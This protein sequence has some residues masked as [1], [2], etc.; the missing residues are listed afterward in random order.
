MFCDQDDF[1]IENKVEIALDSIIQ[2]EKKYGNIPLVVYTDLKVVDEKL[3]NISDSLWAFTK[4]NPE[5]AKKLNLI[6]SDNCIT[7]CTSI[8]NLELKNIINYSSEKIP[9]EAIMHDWWIGIVACV[10]GK[11]E[12]INKSTILYRQHNNNVMGTSENKGFK[13]LF[14][15]ISKAQNI[16]KKLNN[17]INYE[18][19]SQKQAK[20]FIELYSLKLKE[21]DYS[22]EIINNYAFFEY[23]NFLIRKIKR[24]KYGFF[25]D[26][27]IRNLILFMFR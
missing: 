4:L 10:F 16:L 13:K 19:K 15:N 20:K 7:G 23:D 27:S 9:K 12:Y 21:L 17:I 14:S 5:R 1:W 2:Y 8:I 6:L 18:K 22:Y 11:A 3:N 26:D 24:V 25:L